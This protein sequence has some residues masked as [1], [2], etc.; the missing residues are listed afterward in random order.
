M[1]VQYRCKVVED[2]RV[3]VCRRRMQLQTHVESVRYLHTFSVL[4]HIYFM[5]CIQYEISSRSVLNH[6]FLVHRM[7]AASE[8]IFCTAKK[9]VIMIYSDKIRI[10]NKCKSILPWHTK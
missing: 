2:W 10:N 9:V 6:R 7:N 4:V 3:C 8:R 5:S 1:I